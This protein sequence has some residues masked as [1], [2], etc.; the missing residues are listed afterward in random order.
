MSRI[1]R[2]QQIFS[3]IEL[4]LEAG[5][6]E[7]A[8]V[9]SAFLEHDALDRESRLRLLLI[10]TTLDGPAAC[11][12]EIDRLRNLLD[13]SPAERELI[14][15]IFL[16]DSKPAEERARKDS[17]GTLAPT[18]PNDQAPQPLEQTAKQYEQLLRAK[19]AALSAAENRFGEVVGA[20]ERQLGEKQDQLEQRDAEIQ[21]IRANLARL[22]A[23]IEEI[24]RANDRE[25]R[26]L[27]D[28]LARK[29]ELLQEKD[30]AMKKTA[31]RLG[32]QINALEDQLGEKQYLLEAHEREINSLIAKMAELNG[33]H[34]ELACQREESERWMANELREKASLLQAAA[35]AID[36]VKAQSEAK[37]QGLKCELTEKQI[38][39]DK[40]G[41][42]RAQLRRQIDVLAERLGEAEKARNRTETLLHEERHH[43]PPGC[44]ANL[45][46][47]GIAAG[48]P[49]ENLES[50]ADPLIAS[51]APNRDGDPGWPNRFAIGWNIFPKPKTLS[52][53]ALAIA[54]AGL[55]ILPLAYA[56][57]G[58]NRA[59]SDANRVHLRESA[60][61]SPPVATKV[62]LAASG[63][64]ASRDG[65]AVRVPIEPS[66]HTVKVIPPR[67][68][69]V[70]RPTD[71]SEISPTYITRRAVALR[72][73]P[74]FAA[75]SMAEIR[76]GTFVRAL[77]AQGQWL[78]VRIRPAGPVGYV[79]KE[80]LARPRSIQ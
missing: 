4:F 19:D 46:G 12:D 69:A 44:A 25:V 68:V 52:A 39:L 31:E 33:K 2:P 62:P 29:T 49:I 17:F 51:S 48:E 28:S 32:G 10:H 71:R 30:A 64:K 78:K 45:A 67:R 14:R 35:S 18:W 58:P 79:R 40:S 54:G 60:L 21:A 55:L 70:G 74:R 9:L 15:K 61:A 34:A 23:Q 16:V 80:F 42:E 24:D 22:T 26:P 76:A 72:E 59:A 41:A 50:L 47:Q 1:S 13:P 65:Q 57:W 38:L 66:G 63:I 75:T 27:R 37:I 73:A 43:L 6:Y 20:L 5:K 56:F 77:A 11:Q 7:D 3:E 53:K 36:D 8:K